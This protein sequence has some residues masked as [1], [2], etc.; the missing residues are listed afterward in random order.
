MILIADYLIEDLVRGAQLTDQAMLDH[1]GLSNIKRIRSREV[2]EINKDEFYILSSVFQLAEEHIYKLKEYENYIIFEHDHGYVASRN[3]FMIPGCNGWIEN[4]TGIVSQDKQINRELYKKAKAVICL[5]K[6]HENQLRKNLD[7]TF[8]N[9]GGASWRINALNT[10]DDIRNNI[11]KKY[12]YG[13]FNDSPIIKLSNGQIF[14]QGVNIKNKNEALQYC[15]DNKLKYKYIPRI[16]DN[17]KFLS[18]MASFESFIF[19]PKIPE[20][21]SRILTEAKMLDLN[22]IT[23]DN[24]GAVHEDWWKLSG[25][26]L[27]NHFRNVVI[28]KSIEV[29]RRYLP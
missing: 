29:F 27:T 10:I 9:I 19:F 11:K 12:E 2:S 3:P 15:I 28:P 23:N 16:N 21:C 1:L 6:W 25:Q 8:D 5:T 7:G 24:S 4:K 17:K 18:V 20:T 26:E 13:F 14:N 22:V